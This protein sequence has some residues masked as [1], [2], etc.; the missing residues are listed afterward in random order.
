MVDDS[1][2]GQ[3]KRDAAAPFEGW[4]FSHL[5]SRMSEAKPDWDYMAVAKAAVAGS[6][7]LLDMATGGG[8]ALAALAPFPGR[9]TAIE[10]HRPNVA[11]ARRRLAPLGV[12]VVEADPHL[13]L[14]FEDGAF[15][16]I[17]NRHGGFRPT[18]LGRVLR[19]GGVFL[20]QQV[21]GDNLADLAACFDQTA[22]WPDNGL[23]SVIQNLRDLGFD[24]RSARAWRGPVIFLDVGALIYFLTAIPWVVRDFSLAGHLEVLTRLQTKL[25]LGE[26]LR[27]T[28]SR[29]L[30]EAVRP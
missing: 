23:A 25:E 15:D 26:P 22:Q 27:F 6:R 5:D 14:P 18:E 24:I 3:W 21:S 10:G 4:D 12:A 30:I 29:F 1:L 11:V 16:L 9:A 7:D 8:E 20:T 17:L 19:P 13:D 2:I 28:V